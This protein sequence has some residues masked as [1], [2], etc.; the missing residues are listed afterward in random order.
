MGHA[1][2]GSK[3]ICMTS[4]HVHALTWSFSRH[5]RPGKSGRPPLPQLGLQPACCE[6]VPRRGARRTYPRTVRD[7]GVRAPGWRHCPTKASALSNHHHLSSR[8]TQFWTVHAQLEQEHASWTSEALSKPRRQALV[9]TTVGRALGQTLVGI[10]G[11]ARG[12]PSGIEI[13]A[14]GSGRATAAP[15]GRGHVGPWR[16]P[17]ARP[18]TKQL[19]RLLPL[20]K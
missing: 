5:S 3:T 15:S 9:S 2:S 7:R 12:R 18:N 10:P 17:A 1:V 4:C 20:L 16:L 13:A 14:N 8:G 6:L 19:P 11:R